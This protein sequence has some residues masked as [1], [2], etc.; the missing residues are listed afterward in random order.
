MT[1][2]EF[3]GT[4]SVFAGVTP[5]ELETISLRMLEK[6]LARGEMLLY[7]GDESSTLYFVAHGVIRLF[8]TSVEG[9]EQV[10]SIVRPGEMFNMVSVFDGG[11]IPISAQALG[12][13]IVYEITRDDLDDI[14]CRNPKLAMNI[15]HI[16]AQRTRSLIS[17]IEDLSFRSVVS[18]VAKILLENLSDQSNQTHHITQ[19]E[20]AAMAGTAREVVA[21]SLKCLESSGFIEM[22][23]HRIVIRSKKGL[24]Q[25][26]ELGL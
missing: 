7:E 15:I 3:L 6:N 5:L 16:L 12:H 22:H 11:P 23:N 14:L 10:I 8:K 25:V 17:L 1:K 13:A 26:A 9:K 20:M 24:E 4:L 21:R 18:R 2:L 19:R